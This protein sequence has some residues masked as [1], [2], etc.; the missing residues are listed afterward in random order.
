VTEVTGNLLLE[1]C[2]SFD[3][4]KKTDNSLY[5]LCVSEI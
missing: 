1:S 3:K 2:S 4:F 5:Q